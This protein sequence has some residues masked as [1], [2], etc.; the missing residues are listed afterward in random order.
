MS[1]EEICDNA[2]DDDND[3]LIDLNDPDCECEI[4]EFESLIPNPSFEEY[5]CCP[6]DHSQMAC[7]KSWDQASDGTSDF[8]HTC[9]YLIGEEVMLPF[10]DGEGAVL[11]LEGSSDALGEKELYNEYVGVC[12]NSP[13]EKD[14]TYLLKFHLGFLSEDNSPPLNMAFFGSSDCVNL[15]FPGFGCP[16]EHPGWFLIDEERFSPD[17]SGPHWK[18]ISIELTPNEDVN[19]FVLG[20][21]CLHDFSGILDVYFLDNLRLNDPADFAFD[22]IDQVHPCNDDFAFEVDYNANYNYQW[23]KEGI[24]LLGE[25]EAKISM[26]YGEG[27]YQLRIMDQDMQE[28]RITDEFIYSLPVAEHEIFRNLCKGA[29]FNFLGETIDDEGIYTFNLQTVEGCDSIVTLNVELQDGI[30]DTLYAQKLPNASFTIAGFSFESEGL[31]QVDLL[32]EEGC[33]STIIL[34]LENINIYIPNVFSPNGDRSNDFFEVYT[35]SEEF[36]GREMSIFDRWGNLVYKGDKWDGK[37]LNVPAKQGVYLYSIRLT[38]IQGQESFLNGSVT[39][40]R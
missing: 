35:K 8:L 24:A 28:C 1:M 32:T 16:T 3:G 26:M 25:T 22:L 38:D 4:V 15:P 6:T 29:S 10:P 14:S 19:A 39:L 17:E 31:H 13:M 27:N 2:I 9:G 7:A 30:I 33:D 23:Y 5:H 21:D 18:E 36:L 20:G 40:L 37:L 11:F 34:V 12:L